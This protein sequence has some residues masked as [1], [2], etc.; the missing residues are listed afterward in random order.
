MSVDIVV[1]KATGKVCVGKLSVIKLNHE[2]NITKNE[3]DLIV[4]MEMNIVDNSME[5]V[6]DSKFMKLRQTNK[7]KLHSVILA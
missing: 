3:V 2:M 6:I 5:I 4:I 7:R 1:Q